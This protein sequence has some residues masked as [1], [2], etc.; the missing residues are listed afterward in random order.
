[1]CPEDIAEKLRANDLEVMASGQPQESLE[2]LPSPDG[3]TRH[4][5]S[6]RFVFRGASNQILLGVMQVDITERQRA[7]EQV[8][9]A[10]R[11]KTI[12][13]K[14]VHHRVKNNLAVV[15][16]LLAM[17]AETASPGAARALLDSQLRLQSMALLHEYL[18]GTDQ[19]DRV[20]FHDYAQKLTGEL[21][22]AFR[23]SSRSVAIQVDAENLELEL[24]RAIPCGLIL[25]ELVSNALKYGF[26]G[27]RKGTIRVEFRRVA[28]GKLLLAV[29]DDGM[30][31]A[32]GWDWTKAD[33]MGLR[34]VQLL[35]HQLE[36]SL[37]LSPGPGTRF[38]LVFPEKEEKEENDANGTRATASAG[39]GR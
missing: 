21:A 36:G 4:M 22:S 34:I 6:F 19:L 13:L 24:T 28:P 20:D 39:S 35:S 25:N 17:Q 16:S 9:A 30:G 27:W 7:E 31:L 32:P 12:L 1:V 11:E 29:G 37:E 33:S 5:L 18:Y 38:E 23:T 8:R 15:S 26:P 2:T 3:G 14:E 10:L